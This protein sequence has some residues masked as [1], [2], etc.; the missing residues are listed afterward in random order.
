MKN[1][2]KSNSGEFMA[3][4][5]NLAPQLY[6]LKRANGIILIILGLIVVSVFISLRNIPKTAEFNNTAS[7][8]AARELTVSDRAEKSRPFSYYNDI[9]GKH[10]LFK[11]IGGQEG[12]TQ[13]TS[14][15][16]PLAAELLKNYSL[17]GVVGGDDPQAIIEDKKAKQTYY[18]KKGQPLGEYKIRNIQDGRVILENDGQTA[19]LSI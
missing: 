13:K 3:F 12:K 6:L 10:Q 1:I 17:I 7:L 18:L 14:P 15:G 16:A 5:E 4:A 11:I 2:A 19:E 8:S 9:I